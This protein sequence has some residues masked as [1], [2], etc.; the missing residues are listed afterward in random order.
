[1]IKIPREL[2]KVF[3]LEIVNVEKGWH[4]EP[5][6]DTLPLIVNPVPF[7]SGTTDEPIKFGVSVFSHA[8][9]P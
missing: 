7:G 4:Q 8:Q 6:E 3:G 1:M 9:E 2:V 5:N